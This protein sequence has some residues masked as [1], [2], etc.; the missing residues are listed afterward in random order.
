MTLKR[1]LIIALSIFPCLCF[2]EWTN[3]IKN[4]SRNDYKAGSQNWQIMQLDNHWMYFANKMGI[5]EF[6]GKYW[7]L[8]PLKNNTDARSLYYSRNDN[9]TYVGGINEIG[10]LESSPDGKK[11]FRLIEVSNENHT[12][13]LG[14]VWK[15]YEIDKA[16]YFCGDQVVMKW[17]NDVSIPIP[18]PD[19]IDCSYLINNTLYIGTASGIF[20][21][22][23]E[24]FYRLPNTEAMTRQ[25][26][27]AILPFGNKV[28]IASAREGLF[29]W[30]EKGIT[31]FRTDAD[32][33]I[34]KNELFSIA[35]KDNQI[36]IGTVL[37][38]L[39]LISTEG[40]LVKYINESQ[41]LQNN[42]ILSIYFD[43][44]GNLWL[45]LDNG[46]DYVALNYPVTNLYSAY[47]FY[48][49]GYTAQLYRGKLYLG[50][51]RGLY[52]TDWP[53]LS[54][55][56][57]PELK[58][59]EGSQGQVWNLH[60]IDDILYVCHDRGLLFFNS[61]EMK[62]M[63]LHIG[64]WEL[65]QM[66]QAKDKYWISTYNG[67]F[68]MEKN[69]RNGWN[70]RPVTSS[71][72]TMLNSSIINFEEGNGNRL[73]LR[74]NRNEL[75]RVL[76]NSE[77]TRVENE[78]Y[79]RSENDIPENFYIHQMMG[80]IILCSPSGFFFY[81]SKEKFVPDEQL[82]RFFE[83]SG[84]NNS[85]KSTLQTSNAEWALG[86]DI[87]AVKYRNSAFAFYHTIPLITNF[88]RIIPITDS[89]VII[90]NENGFALWNTVSSIK[91]QNYPL[92]I[93]DIKIIKGNYPQENNN[94][95]SDVTMGLKIP[96]SNNSLL[97]EYGLISY[98]NPSK[99]Q[100]R[101][102]IDNEE[103]SAF[104]FSETK[105]LSDM[106]IGPHTF[107]VQAQLENS[108]LLEDSFSFIILPP[109]YL[110]NVAY[111]I[112]IILVIA[113][114][115]LIWE[116]D[117]RRL[118]RKEK[119]IKMRQQKELELKE[120]TFKLES[121]KKEQEIIRLTNEKLETDIQHKSQEL[122]NSAIILG[123]KNEVLIEI[124][125]YLSSIFDKSGNAL[126]SQDIKRKILEMYNIIDENI[127]EDDVLH[128]FE[129]NFDLVHNNFIKR[130]TETFPTLSVAE[131]KMC[132]YIKMQLSSKEI[133]PLLNITVRGVETMR[134]RLRKKLGLQ[135]ES[136]TKFLA[137]F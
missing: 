123:R 97:V 26:L 110:T 74:L 95:L 65:R 6:N 45:G 88:E 9:R 129:E 136:L 4:Y 18:A 5:L 99:V 53:V 34:K 117:N 79:Y 121:E 29:L 105:A 54:K 63:D 112:Y 51:N 60:V 32:E 16:I 46:I 75:S 92:Q 104:S 48:G 58:L 69:P 71:Q 81:D 109:W 41:G 22:A 7:N 43:I 57:A 3:L 120:K 1:Y 66:K 86:E 13:N 100:F 35:I 98:F 137:N 37:K 28:M 33:F 133:A 56:S 27:R 55:E 83:F 59:I 64:V 14:N 116:F 76:L 52:V 21:L 8:Y 130:L 17:M 125:K 73:F 106:R 122:A 68:V 113:S 87:L 132:T 114:L 101:T 96:Y 40:K 10:Y 107:V 103:W 115:L 90:P 82:N 25:K 49:A 131:R 94:I 124:K 77:L 2:A 111:L 126:S 72:E 128:R 84:K 11:Q 89:S 44:N 93:T 19:K 91:K 39:V 12:L 102:R 23:G 20:I 127:R 38:G 61:K 134:L 47:G 31:P 42:T 15:I 119:K 67:F 78:K 70:I 108:I 118:K 62:S 135:N 80:K 24:A 30:D 85:I 36:A 50:T